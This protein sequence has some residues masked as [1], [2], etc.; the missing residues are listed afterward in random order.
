MA[1]FGY[2]GAITDRIA[3]EHDQRLVRHGRPSTEEPGSLRYPLATGP[4]LTG[5]A[6][7]RPATA[8]S[9]LDHIQYRLKGDFRRS[10][11][12]SGSC[13]HSR[14]AARTLL[15]HRNFQ[16]THNPGEVKPDMYRRFGFDLPHE[17]SKEMD[18]GGSLVR[19]SDSRSLYYTDVFSGRGGN[20]VDGTALQGSRQTQTNE[21]PH[22]AKVRVASSIPVFRSKLPG[23]G[24]FFQSSSCFSVTRRG[25]TRL[26]TADR[27]SAFEFSLLHYSAT[28]LTVRVAV[29]RAFDEYI[30]AFRRRCRRRDASQ[31]CIADRGR[32]RSLASG[33]DRRP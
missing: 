18:S 16:T 1:L 30:G 28:F 21:N 14:P 12:A 23:Q 6:A 9:D 31:Q 5:I 20:R 4:A 27:R 15:A 22:L 17:L 2:G 26:T 10:K 33:R 8:R 24:Q 32:R 13:P 29:V 25:S 7:R 11:Q 19:L 3:H